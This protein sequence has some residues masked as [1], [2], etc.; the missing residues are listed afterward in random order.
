MLLAICA[1]NSP[2]TGE[3]PAQRPVT[4]SFDAFLNLHL[5]KRLCKQWGWWFETPSRPL[6]RH[7]HVIMHQYRHADITHL[8]NSHSSSDKKVTCNVVCI[9][10]LSA[11]CHMSTEYIHTYTIVTIPNRIRGFFLYID[12]RWIY[13]YKAGFYLA[14]WQF[15]FIQSL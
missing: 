4:R 8:L 15:D 6:W 13:K 5:N 9:I 14:I 11:F 7:C 12:Y 1:W 3:F 2:V 10:S